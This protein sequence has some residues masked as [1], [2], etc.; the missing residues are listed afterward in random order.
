MR[1]LL[2]EGKSDWSSLREL[3]QPFPD[4]QL[5]D[6]QEDPYEIQNLAD[7]NQP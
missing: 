3:M 2:A 1:Q 7:S 5:Y 6:T 4:E